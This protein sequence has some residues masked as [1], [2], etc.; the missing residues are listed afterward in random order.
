M[1]SIWSR[2][3]YYSQESPDTKPVLICSQHQAELFLHT[4]PKEGLSGRGFPVF[5]V[6]PKDIQGRVWGGRVD[7][8][9][10]LGESN[11]KAFG[12]THY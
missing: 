2:R 10:E 5:C 4:E 1:G 11:L 9:A 3:G 8:G 12:S 7:L 6:W